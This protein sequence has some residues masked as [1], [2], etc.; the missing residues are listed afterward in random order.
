[1][2]TLQFEELI[3]LFKEFDNEEDALSKLE[4]MRNNVEEMLEIGIET[5]KLIS[6]WKMLNKIIIE[7]IQ[8]RFDKIYTKVN[9]NE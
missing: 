9:E 8:N 4:N 5:K 3:K 7:I 6:I 2:K 1:M